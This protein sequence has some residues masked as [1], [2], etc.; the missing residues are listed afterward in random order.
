[1]Q[2]SQKDIQVYPAG[3]QGIQ[4]VFAE[5][6]SLRVSLRIQEWVKLLEDLKQQKQLP[7]IEMV[8]AYTSLTIYYD[9]LKLSFSEL[10][11]KIMALEE[12]HLNKTV[13]TKLITIP[14]CYDIS[15]GIDLERLA[16]L[17]H[18]SV[19]E[20]IRLH[21]E[22][23]YNIYMLGFSPGFPY[24]GGLNPRLATPR[25]DQPRTLVK[26]GSVG[27]AGSQTGVYTVDSPGGWN[28]IGRTPLSLYHP[29]EAQPFLLRAGQCI[30]FKEIPLALYHECMREGTT[31]SLKDE[32]YIL[33]LS[34]EKEAY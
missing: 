33:N 5:Q 4:L 29:E 24:L 6:P 28:I 10:V 31:I 18:L 3:E 23:V 16:Q 1:M 20:I 21:T 25:L 14:V 26:A 13:E 27:I 2:N 30:R 7:I 15:L 9:C 32:Q 22:P 19:E 17:H 8:P 34:N 12:P 11:E